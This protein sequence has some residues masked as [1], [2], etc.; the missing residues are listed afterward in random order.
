MRFRSVLIAVAVLIAGWSLARPQRQRPPAPPTPDDALNFRV[1]F[2]YQRLAA[3][4]YDGSVTVTGGRLLRLDPWRFFP[5]DSI[6]DPNAWKLTTRR[7]NFENQPDRPTLI[8]A[9]SGAVQNLVPAGIVVSV[10]AGAAAA[11]FQTAQGNFSVPLAGLDYGKVLSYLDGDVLVQRVPSVRQVANSIQEQDFPSIAVT[12]G[13]VLWTAW[14]GYRERSDT[15]WVRQDGAEPMALTSGQADVYRTTIGEDSAGGIHVVWSEQ[16]AGEWQLAERV[17]SGGAWSARRQITSGPGPNIFQK[18][19]G[20]HLI[21]V[22]H[23]EGKS[24]LSVADWNGTRWSAPRRAGGP[25]VWSPD[26]AVDKQGNLHLAWD[27]YEKGNY[28][29]YY[30]RG[31]DPVEQVTT[32]PRF[33]AHASLA[34]DGQ[35][36][37]WLAWDESGANWGKDWSHD[38]QYRATVLYSDR[39]IRVA[40]KDAGGWKE[41]SEFASAVPERSR[42][43]WQLPKLAADRSG[44]I[45]AMFQIRTSAINNRDDYWCSGGLWDL[46]LTTYEN[47]VWRPGAL[48]PNS[49]ARPEAPFQIVPGPD[50]VWM[51]WATDGRQVGPP[52]AFGGRTMV[53]YDVYTGHAATASPAGAPVLAEMTERPGRPQLMHPNETEDVR[54][55][56]DYRTTAGGK[57]YRIMRGDFHRH[58]EISS[59]GSGDGSLEDYYRYMIDGASMDTGIV[60]DHNM[61]GDV[62]YSWWRTEK[63][64]DVFRI[65]GRFLPLFGYERSVSF[66]NGHRNMVFDHRGVRTLKITPEEQQGRVNSGSLVYP[67]LRQN[68]GICMEHSLATGQ[69]TDYRDNDPQLEPLVELYQGYHASYEYKGAPRAEGDARYLSVHGG[70]QPEGFWWNALKK[71]LKLGVQASSDHISTH[72]SYAMIFT[73]AADR[74]SLVENMRARHAYAATDNIIVDFSS[75]GHMMGEA[76]ATK[77]VP[78]LTAR[79]IG[80]DKLMQVDLVRNNEFIY[81]QKP[82]RRESSFDYADTSAKTGENYYYVRVM[83]EDGNLAWSSPIWITAKTG[84]DTH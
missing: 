60:G 83:Q 22:S 25:S 2:G 46:F 57:S 61:G 80:T 3:R 65:A 54:R 29:I 42:R 55:I 6:Q 78:K 21:W 33:Q 64:Y 12:R 48:I 75:E 37:P 30:R 81:T 9:G 41:T 84:T 1:T 79:V 32:A 56:R 67:Y 13:G 71:G 68:R 50:R 19:A 45:W 16:I 66:P 38:D 43:Y 82:G 35:G 62:E 74:T 34:I 63:S 4:S 73:P 52:G 49:T 24:W 5:T 39:S 18:L 8:S 7:M 17:F 70:Y 44:R 27:S 58:T 36:R 26:A 31:T 47:G 23:A 76:F 14:Q 72:C 59:D 40:V 69:G 11:E 77:S 15:V 51:T 53:K 28:D 20:D 10:A